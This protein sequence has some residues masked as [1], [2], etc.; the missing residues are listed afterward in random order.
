MKMD[1]EG[2]RDEGGMWKG[3]EWGRRRENANDDDRIPRA[4]VSSMRTR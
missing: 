4:R 1:A 3:V 2:K